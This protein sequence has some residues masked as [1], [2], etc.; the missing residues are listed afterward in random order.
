MKKFSFTINGN[1]YDVEVKNIEDNIAHLEVNGTNYEVE[2]NREMK[3]TKTPTLVRSEVPSHRRESK[4]KKSIS[5]QPSAIKAPLP[6]NILQVF[7][8]EGDT[9]KKGQKLLTYEAMKM[10]N[11]VQA[12]KDGTIKAVKVAPGDAVLEGQDLMEIV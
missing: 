9:V 11:E 10:E 12:T 6:G 8:N 4:I 5:S 3:Q 2:I 1:Q 7:V